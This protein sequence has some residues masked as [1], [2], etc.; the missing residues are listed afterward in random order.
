MYQSC[1]FQYPLL[2]FWPASLSP[3]A[4]S[5]VLISL[6]YLSVAG[7]LFRQRRSQPAPLR[8]VFALLAVFAVSCALTHC[9]WVASTGAQK[10]VYW[11][12][13]KCTAALLTAGVALA[14]MRLLPRATS[15]A[16][17]ERNEDLARLRLLAAAVDVSGDGMMIADLGRENS[18]LSIVY[19]NPAFERLTGYSTDEAVGRSPS[20]LPDDEAGPAALDTVRSAMRSKTMVR[21]EV[22]SR[23]KDGGR[24]WTEWLV[25]PVNDETGQHTHSVVV[26]RDTTERRR[27]EQAIRESEERFRGLFEQAADAIFVIEGVG[28]IVDVNRRA[29]HWLGY[30]R[31]ELLSMRMSDLDAG[32]RVQELSPGDT[33]TSETR[34]RRKDGAPLPVEVRFAVLELAGRKLKLALVRDLT[35]RRQAEQK[36]KEREEL[37]RNIITH[38]PCGVFWKDRNLAYLG[39]N[40]QVARDLGLAA[41][42]DLVGLTDFDWEVTQDEARFY[43]ECDRQVIESGKAILNIEET[44]TRR[45]GTRLTLLTSKVPLRDASGAVVGVLGVYQ[46]ITSRK[47]LEEQLRQAQKLDAVGR[48]AGGIAHDFN[49]ILT[50]IRGNSELIRDVLEDA[51]KI[52]LV[53][54]VCLAA[55]RAAGLVRQLLTFS[56]RQSVCPEVV[57]LNGIVSGLTGMMRRLLGERIAI[58]TRLAS[59]PVTTRADYRHLEQV[60]VNLAVNARDAMP[61]GGTLTIG[62]QIV[63]VNDAGGEPRRMSRFWVSD[64]GM[65]MNEEVKARIFEP[66]FTTKGPDKGTGL[67]LATVFGIVEQ[68]GGRIDVDSSPGVGTTFRIDFPWCDSLPSMGMATP[69]PQL[70]TLSGS[71]NSG[72]VLLVEDEES[73][74]KLARMALESTGYTVVDAP[75]ADSALRLLEG[76]PRIDLLVTDLT[77]PGSDGWEL[78]CQ[79]RAS[80]PDLAV[81]VMSGY[82][83]DLNW[84]EGQRNA[85]FLSKPFAPVELIRAANRVV[86]QRS[87]ESTRSIPAPAPVLAAAAIV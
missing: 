40:E 13:A 7:V 20:I 29:C 87:V 62:T 79:I 52:G 70:R 54:E 8:T 68:A 82:V 37:L 11:E 43:Q 57:D 2:A 35:R 36:L 23:R 67:G 21:V 48:L 15:T 80:H 25:V 51:G 30:S 75:D 84:L 61:E 42:Q 9:L 24:L 78:A 49:N 6:A 1:A 74:R 14:L 76:M 53:D 47:R 27:V 28:R 56:R 55:D 33:L 77:M 65:G 58:E 83:S 73:V 41:P 39:C 32:E 5:N 86:S 26:L 34:Y 44:Q 22:P 50:V 60:V 72:T 46:D 45:D 18:Q 19:A 69:L 16:R 85:V 4:W 71:S 17:D 3:P 59:A 38:I 81:V 31:S 12:A 64:T 63:D 66:F 10:T